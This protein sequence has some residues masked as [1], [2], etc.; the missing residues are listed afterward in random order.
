MTDPPITPLKPLTSLCDQTPPP[1]PFHTRLPCTPQAPITLFNA[2]LA[3]HLYPAG[4][5]LIIRGVHTS[6]EPNDTAV[7]Q[8]DKITSAICAN[9]PDGFCGCRLVTTL[10]PKACYTTCMYIR[11]HPDLAPTASNPEPRVDW[12]EL[13]ADSIRSAAPAWEVAWAP[14]ANKDKQMWLCI[15]DIFAVKDE[16]DNDNK[17]KSNNNNKTKRR[18]P[19]ERIKLHNQN[20]KVIDTLRKHFDDA[21]H[22]AVDGYR[23]GK[24][25]Q[26]VIVL[27]HPAHVDAVL[28]TK[29]ITVGA[30]THAISAVRQIEIEHPFEIAVCS[31]TT[32]PE[33]HT[34]QVCDGW[35][36]AFHRPD[37]TTLLTET[38][39]GEDVDERDFMFYTMADWA[40]TKCVL[41]AKL[42]ETFQK[43]TAVFHLQPPQLLY[44]INS[45]STWKTRDTASAIDKGA[46]KIDST[47]GSVIHRMEAIEHQAQACHA[48]T[49]ARMGQMESTL[50]TVA[51]SVPDV[52]G[53]VEDLGC[54]LFIGQQDAHLSID[55]SRVDND[56]ALACRTINCPID[57]DEAKEA[58]TE[59]MCLK[60]KCVE[61]MA[62]LDALRDRTNSC[63]ITPPG[64]TIAL[65][66]LPPRNSTLPPGI[67]NKR[68][69]T[70]IHGTNPE[71]TTSNAHAPLSSTNDMEVDDEGSILYHA[72]YSR[73]PNMLFFLAAF[74]ILASVLQVVATISVPFSIYALN[75]NSLMDSVKLH[76]INIAINAH[77]PHAFV[78]SESKT[79]SKTGP[80]LPNSDYNIFEEP[81]VQSDNFHTYKWGVA[82]GI[83]KNLQ[84][85]QRV[86]INTTS[87]HGRAV[88]VDIV[89]PTTTGQGF[90]HR[91]ISAY[92]P[93]DPGA[94]NTRDFWP[95]LT[96]LVNS[97]TTSWSIASDLNTTVSTSERASG[98][99][100]A[101][102]QYLKFL[103]DVN[104]IDIWS[105]HPE[106]NRHFDWTS[107]AGIDA[108]TGNII[109]HVVTSKRQYIDAE[110]AVAD[111]SQDF[112]P[113]TNHRTVTGHIQLSPPD[114]MG[115]TV[116]PTHKHS[117]NAARIKFPTRAEKSRYE[118]SC[119]EIEKRLKMTDLYDVCVTD[120]APFTDLYQHFTN[121]LIPASEKAYGRVNHNACRS[122]NRVTNPTIEKLI[123][124]LQFTGGAIRFIKTPNNYTLSH[125]ACIT[126]FNLLNTYDTRPVDD[127]NM[128][129]IQHAQLQRK[130]LYR[131]LFKTHALEI[132]ARKEH[133]DRAR[134]TNTLQGSSTKRLIHPGEFID[135]PVTLNHLHSDLLVSDPS[136][137]KKLTCEYWSSLYTHDPPP[138]IPKPWLTTKSVLENKQC[139]AAQPFQWPC[140]ASLSDFRALLS[141]GTPRL[142]PEHDQW[143][144]WVIKNLPTVGSK[145]SFAYTIT[146]ISCWAKQHKVTGM[147]DAVSAYRLPSAIIDLDRATQTNTKCHI[148]TA[149]GI[150]E[151]ILMSGLTKQGGSLSSVKLTLIMGLG[152][153]YLNNLLANDPDTLII[154]T[155]NSSKGD[156]HLADDHLSSKVVMVEATNNS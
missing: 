147:Y 90:V 3:T 95:D 85:A 77:N 151:P 41:S 128:T 32:F 56:M 89:L 46:K 37:G 75:S 103:T 62:K 150:T 19:E 139:V 104:A 26:A 109:D 38:R 141:K 93:W 72:M 69:C 136:E 21:G 87:L 117:L 11:I 39:T 134:I 70:S 10:A 142:A 138:N 40:T 31:F 28:R 55:L 9:D 47:L 34:R 82:V 111:R 45:A 153:H 133:Q 64:P 86:T 130:A 132:K 152:H 80:N 54:V 20:Q 22:P 91:M 137:V 120:D 7:H 6:N 115:T 116:F 155:A 92:A 71:P 68:P 124:R 113:S 126:H 121:V 25:T 76:H 51:T 57:E 100:N 50:A 79:N 36:D 13:I 125:G 143:E 43:A 74:T 127:V 96:A 17:K 42:S 106:Q 73:C 27:A 12:L 108:S 48:A 58:T 129:L 148:R 131:D 140:Q 66:P 107:R 118:D 23:L 24:S 149:Y 98:G 112:I 101:W 5:Y 30:C 99:T 135:L 1:S 59:Y 16:A 60:A 88:T 15:S 65:P 154:S 8:V 105:N 33:S 97:T 63:L 35:F 123:A 61:I 110:I 156:P 122:N 14:Q 144:K 145:S 81:G 49:K 78:L 94:A 29:T 67:P 2:K 83:R 44:N 146:F 18:D 52:V 53:H 102:A 114:G 84:I 119:T 4:D